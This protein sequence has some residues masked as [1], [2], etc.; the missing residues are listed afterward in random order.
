MITDRL[1][2]PDPVIARPPQRHD[3]EKRK[4]VFR[5]FTWRARGA[6]PLS[7]LK[8]EKIHWRS[9]S[10]ATG[11]RQRRQP[12]ERQHSA[13]L[14]RTRD[15]LPSRDRLRSHPQEGHH[16]DGPEPAGTRDRTPPTPTQPKPPPVL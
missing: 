5:R 3:P 8:S 2:V 9:A 12:Q 7:F 10:K 13:A 6:E 16:S 15:R 11:N 1:H 14:S 4:P